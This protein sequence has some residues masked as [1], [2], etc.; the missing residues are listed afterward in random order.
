MGSSAR[1]FI[2]IR[3]ANEVDDILFLLEHPNTYTLG[4]TAD[5]ENLIGSE[6]ISEAKSNFC[7]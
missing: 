1:R 3:V 5:K 6:D 7:L 2:Q 4:K